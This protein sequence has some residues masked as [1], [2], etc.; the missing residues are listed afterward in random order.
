MPDR[1]N[2]SRQPDAWAWLCSL[3][4]G[5]G[6]DL[7]RMPLAEAANRAVSRLEHRRAA[8]LSLTPAA[9]QLASLLVRLE[10]QSLSGASST[11]PFL[12]REYARVRARWLADR[13]T[14]G[15]RVWTRSTTPAAEP[16]PEPVSPVTLY[17]LMCL[18]RR[19]A[20]D[21]KRL[22]SQRPTARAAFPVATIPVQ[23]QE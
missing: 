7:E 9:I 21:L 4:T 17:D 5:E 18:C 11:E 2:S 19:L 23:S 8:G 22:R 13:Y 16:E 3:A 6:I 12:E 14:A 1:R 20:D 15:Q 10:G